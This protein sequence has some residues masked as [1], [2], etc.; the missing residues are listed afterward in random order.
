MIA[1]PGYGD[2]ITLQDRCKLSFNGWFTSLEGGA[3]VECLLSE[4][5]FVSD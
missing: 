2:L 5:N 3:V 4:F 1:A